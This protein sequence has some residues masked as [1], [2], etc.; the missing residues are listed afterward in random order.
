MRGAAFSHA[1]N[2]S[3]PML[4]SNRGR[5]MAIARPD[6]RPSLMHAKTMASPVWA[7]LHSR[8]FSSAKTR[9]PPDGRDL[10]RPDSLGMFSLSKVTVLDS[11]P[12][13]R[14]PVKGRTGEP[15]HDRESPRIET[16]SSGNG[17]AKFPR[18]AEIPDQFVARL[19]AGGVERNQPRKQNAPGPFRSTHSW[20]ALT[21]QVS[22]LSL[23]RDRMQGRPPHEAARVRSRV[24]RTPV[25]SV[26]RS[27]RSIH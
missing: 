5:S 6:W 7:A 17:L 1:R 19:S 23:R 26:P 20:I 18:F 13:S 11:L 27:V 21:D 25:P 14:A 9:S 2:M 12:R 10:L 8:P 4:A 24:A 15:Q 16:A 3:S 22:W